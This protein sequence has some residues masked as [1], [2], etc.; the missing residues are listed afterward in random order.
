MNRFLLLLLAFLCV[1]VVAATPVQVHGMLQAKGNR[2]VDQS[3]KPTRLMG[4]SM[5]WSIWGGEKFYTTGTINWLVSDWKC[6]LIRMALSVEDKTYDAQLKLAR[7]VIDAA[8]ANG[9]YVIVDWHGAQNAA[10]ASRFYTDIGTIY[11]DKPNLIW[12]IWN[13]P[14]GDGQDW[15][16]VKAMAA[17]VIPVIR[18]YSKSLIVVG[19]P[20]WSQR[21]DI[22]AA[23]PIKDPNVAYTLHFYAASHKQWARDLGNKALNLGVPLFITEWGTTNADGGQPANPGL[24]T[25]EA[26]IWLKWAKD[27]YISTANWSV[28]NFPETSAILG[29]N[30]SASTT[31]GWDPNTLSPSGKWVRRQ[32]IASNKDEWSGT[33]AKPKPHKGT[34][35]RIRDGRIELDESSLG[36]WKEIVVGT[37]DGRVLMRG[38]PSS[39][40]GASLDAKGVVWIELRGDS[41]REIVPTLVH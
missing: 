36:S 20:N 29:P 40:Q 25:A 10:L 21:V 17:Q 14:H 38:A 1:H 34:A 3:G 8:I 22:A 13:E 18:K 23:D 27:N 5:Y 6:N 28:V 39:L 24:D 32:I 4:M 7:T 37:P 31:G 41:R 15:A 11:G 35:A 26:A 19:T 30:K 9:I 33:Y 16:A 2:I 12:E